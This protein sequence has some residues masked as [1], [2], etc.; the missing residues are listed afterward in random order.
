MIYIE[1]PITYCVHCKAA[2]LVTTSRS[3]T[4]GEE[5]MH[6]VGGAR[7][8]CVTAWA[9]RPDRVSTYVMIP[10][11]DAVRM[12]ALETAITRIS[13]G[14]YVRAPGGN[15]THEKARIDV[16]MLTRVRQT[17]ICKTKHVGCSI[18]GSELIVYVPRV[19]L[20][21]VYG[22]RTVRH[23]GFSTRDECVGLTP[24]AGLCV[25]QC[26]S[27]MNKVAGWATPCGLDLQIV[28]TV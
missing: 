1:L 26:C 2:L 27:T 24:D 23:V 9:K 14:R 28:L 8:K 22:C 11:H 20:S 13:A 6:F 4:D 15:D 3:S 7:G 25:V 19:Q 21:R 5:V 17:D 16:S 18:W 10:S 12:T